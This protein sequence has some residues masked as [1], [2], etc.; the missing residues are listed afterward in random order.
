MALTGIYDSAWNADTT[1]TDGSPLTTEFLNSI[2]STLGN[3]GGTVSTTGALPSPASLNNGDWYLVIGGVG[4]SVQLAVVKDGVWDYIPLNVGTV[5]GTVAAGNDSRFPTSDQKAALAGTSGA[6]STS[7]KYVTNADSRLSD[8]RTPT[9]HNNSYHTETYIT[10]V[11][12]DTSPQLGGNLNAAAKVIYDAE[13]K[14]YAETVVT[15]NTST[16]ASLSLAA[17]N[18]HAVNIGGNCVLS[19]TNPPASGKAG[20]ITVII[21]RTAD[22]PDI[23]FGG[24]VKWA[25]G[26]APVFNGKAT[27][28][29]DIVTLITING[30]T[31]WYGF[32]SGEGMA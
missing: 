1:F 22:N 32:V 25:G 27:G 14:D 20:S 8:A 23:S 24:T 4:E 13:I 12:S 6:P 3:I 31:T 21:N 9:V 5:S 29:I 26:V 28:V 18:I 15:T 7:N 19:L 2:L 11:V 30:G 10:A 17:G 16:N